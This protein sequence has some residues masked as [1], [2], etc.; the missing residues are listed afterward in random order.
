[1]HKILRCVYQYT[2][3]TVHTPPM[4]EHSLG[5]C[6]NVNRGCITPIGCVNNFLLI[7][8]FDLI[9]VPMFV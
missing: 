1:M 5:V 9:S 8:S 7:V 4:G 6:V 3:R 2:T